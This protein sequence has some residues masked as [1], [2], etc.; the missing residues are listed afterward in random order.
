M[1][2]PCLRTYNIAARIVGGTSRCGR[3][4]ASDQATIRLARRT[5]R[6]GS[7]HQLSAELQTSVE[8]RLATMARRSA[9]PIVASALDA[10][11]TIWQT[12]GVPVDRSKDSHVRP[13]GYPNDDGS[14]LNGELP[15]LLVSVTSS[16]VRSSWSIRFA[17]A[18]ADADL[19]YSRPAALSGTAARIWHRRPAR[20]LPSARP[21]SF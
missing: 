16:D 13:G 12:I 14:S 8:W 17:V 18:H 5:R 4:R 20:H 9:R 19:T 11:A 1:R 7:V 21:R 6:V 15:A 3:T 10:A 2:R